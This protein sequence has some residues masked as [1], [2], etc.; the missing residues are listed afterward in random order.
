MIVGSITGPAGGSLLLAITLIGF[1]IWLQ[2]YEERNQSQK[3]PKLDESEID[4][5][6]LAARARTRKRANLLIGISGLLILTTAFISHPVTW[7]S[8]WLLVM[9]CLLIVIGLA[10]KDTV[11]TYRYHKEK[12]REV[13]RMV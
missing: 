11:R 1:A 3:Q 4:R 6:Y 9:L 2:R 8:I 5:A 13:Q 10:C 7:M 12:L